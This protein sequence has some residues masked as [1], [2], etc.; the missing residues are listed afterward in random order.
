V[1]ETYQNY[2]ATSFK[3][4]YLYDRY[5]NR[6]I[7]LANTDPIGGGV[8]R[9]DFKAL[10]A[11]NRLVAQ[12]DTTG[13][14]TS[15]DQM[16][17]DKAGNLV[18]DNFSPAPSQR[19]SMTYDAENRMVTAVNGTQR[20]RYDANG[21]RVKRQVG[22][23]GEVWQVYSPDGELLAEYPKQGA[24]TVPTKEYG[25]RG[26][27]MLVVFDSTLTGDDQLK[28]M[29]TDHLGSTRM[30]VNKSGSL[31]GIRRRDYLPF[32]EELA[33]SVGHRAASGSGYQ[34]TDK[35]RQ[36]FGSKERDAETGLD[37]FGARYFASVQ[38]RFTS[39]DDFTK[40][41]DVSDPQSWNKYVYVRNNPLRYIDPSGEKATVTI[42]TDEEHKRGKITIKA[43]IALWTDKKSGLSK[44]DLQ[45]A[46]ASYKKQIEAGWNGQSKQGDITYTV[47]TSVDVQVYDSEGAATKSGAQNVLE[48]NNG[49]VSGNADSY[50]NPAPLFGGPD[51]GKWN[52]QTPFAAHEFGHLLGVGDRKQGPELMNQNN[53]SVDQKANAYDYGWAF[54]GAINA[55]RGASR[56]TEIR[57]GLNSGVMIDKGNPRSS[58]TTRELRKGRFWDR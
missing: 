21:R 13:D 22:Q 31:A 4:S 42:E 1:T 55:H 44:E 25:Y 6:R 9:L 30:I 52:N 49:A 40:D 24:A 47:E 36:K 41:S 14:E 11:T 23:A 8:T 16:R 43:S 54:G 35:P 17:Y 28:W 56:P 46:A 15:S 48:V 7:D 5:G 50:V 20:Y 45:K 58:I 39:P 12:S 19:G 34:V 29:V 53:F 38:G 10:T 26:G 18:Y 32:G 37:Y 51:T 27:Q 3:Q 33:A 57:Y 2:A